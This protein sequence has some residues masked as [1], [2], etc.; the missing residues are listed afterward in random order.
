MKCSALAIAFA[1]LVLMWAPLTLADDVN[2]TGQS[3][4]NNAEKVGTAAQGGDANTMGGG[5]A[6][7]TSQSQEPQKGLA[8]GES[9]G[10]AKLNAEANAPL[11][12]H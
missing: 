5:N 6:A 12:K 9:P 7:A 1:S 2:H 3:Q 4:T 11:T 10:E 8:S